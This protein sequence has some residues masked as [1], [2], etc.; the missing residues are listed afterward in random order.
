MAALLVTTESKM[1]LSARF[2][3]FRLRM[4]VTLNF[5]DSVSVCLVCIHRA[6]VN[7]FK[8]K[9]FLLP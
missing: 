4:F 2:E 8:I 1:K 9:I 3:L 7:N 6:I 5:H